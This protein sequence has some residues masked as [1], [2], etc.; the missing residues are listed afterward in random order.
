MPQM[1]QSFVRGILFLLALTFATDLLAQRPGGRGGR[2]RISGTVTGRILDN[3]SGRPI[4]GATVAIWRV[5]DSS[6]VTGGVSKADG[7]I[8]IEGM[9]P[10]RFYAKIGSL[11]YRVQ[12]VDDLAIRPGSIEVDL[13]TIRLA[14]DQGVETQEVTVTAERPDVEFK[15]DRTI[16]NVE[17]QP[18]NAGGDGIDVLR[19]VPQVEVDIDDN[20][21]LRGSQNVAVLLNG[22]S[23]PLR[24][25][26][27]AGFLRS[28]SAN[29]IRSIEIIPNPSAKYD[30]DGMAG[31]INIV[32]KNEKKEDN[33][34]G[35][36]T[37]SAGTTN[38][39]N[40][41]GSL[42]W[43]SEKLKI[44]SGYS[45]RYD[46]RESERLLFRENRIFEPVTS[47]DQVSKNERIRRPHS[48]N[49]TIE[50]AF[51][52]INTL[53]LAS[54]VSLRSG[55]RY[56][57]VNYTEMGNLDE[58]TSQTFRY[59]LEDE[60]ELSIDFAL[61]YQWKKE[62]GRHE[63]SVEAR[64]NDNSEE[65]A[66]DYVEYLAETTDS[67]VELQN[68]LSDESNSEGTFQI[69]YVR[70]I[71]LTGRLEGG[72]KGEL[73]RVENDYY[74]ET[75]N[76]IT[77]EFQPDTDLNNLFVYDQQLHSL[78]LILG[79]EF[80][81]F[82]AQVGL[83]TE[84]AWTNFNLKTTNEEFEKNYFHLFPSGALSYSF[85]DVSRLRASYS[86]RV[87]RPS[88][89]QL[90]PFPRSPDR[91]NLR[92]GNPYLLP[93][94]V[95]S[96]EI[97]LSQSI[98]W[99]TLSLSPYF[100][101]TTNEIERFFSLD[102]SG[103]STLTYR[104]FNESDSYGAEFV[105]TFRIKDRFTGFINL[106]GYRIVTDADNV[107]SDLSNDAFSWSGRCNG[108]VTIIPDL[109]LQLSYFYRAPFDISNGRINAIHSADLALKQSFL[110]D[111]ASLS[112]RISDLFDTRGF[113]LQRDD[114]EYYIEVDARR[115][116]RTAW[117]SFSWNFGRK[118][119]RQKKRNR[120]GERE[121]GGEAPTGIEF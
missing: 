62:P 79:E 115:D 27:L 97:S 114:D 119:D 28:L 31:I 81:P 55:D 40:S 45:F 72:Y 88:V 18:V 53:S 58:I 23:V 12:V 110:N 93:E 102:S 94:F 113:S 35:T 22:R 47:L 104:N 37:L 80:G 109:D 69:D 60:N 95:H 7:R 56:G 63:F 106:S 59:N 100:R 78:Y 83:R 107:E 39:Y 33:L 50:Y 54:F 92:I 51:D 38:S 71:G 101:H 91:L 57:K 2:G 118:Q 19:N 64:Y 74:S 32:L 89:R 90:N 66:N 86:R 17:N 8:A 13:G 25:E 87:R 120:G 16:Y 20:I 108:K 68:I 77:E 36:V 14:T 30:P 42:N 61:G 15:A 65:E 49:S 29:D 116:S 117:L 10:G 26:A 85:S 111:R 67:I 24:G 9:P 103:I 99:G 98:E 11:G 70:P 73:N 4:P 105:G 121:A 3:E 21:S 75:F 112:L 6:L 82:D 84:Q 76:P 43:R 34:S 41:S 48:L 1:T 44:Y 52:K 96:F 5:R 46:Q